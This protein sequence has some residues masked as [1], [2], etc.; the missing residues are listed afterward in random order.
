MTLHDPSPCD[1]S[2]SAEAAHATANDEDQQAIEA[3]SQNSSDPNPAQP[4]MPSTEAEHDP[5]IDN[6]MFMFPVALFTTLGIFVVLLIS[7]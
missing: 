4:A 3:S 6:F 7:S 2:H 1:D 5:L